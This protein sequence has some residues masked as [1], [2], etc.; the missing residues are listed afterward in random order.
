MS[1]FWDVVQL[2]VWSFF[3]VFYLLVLFQIIGDLFRDAELGG[4]AKAVWIIGL[5]VLPMLT[6]L[7]YIIARGKG[8]AER[9]RASLQRAKDETNSYIRSVSAKSPAEQIADAKSLLDSGAISQS[10]FALLK[11]KALQ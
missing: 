3:F 6:A 1:G 11:S 2:L 9:Q 4:W 8:M 10:E 7:I 5:F